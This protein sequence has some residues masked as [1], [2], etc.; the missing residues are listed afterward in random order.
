MLLILL[1]TGCSS[2]SQVQKANLNDTSVPT[3]TPD[4]SITETPAA[5]PT[6]T[7]YYTYPN[8]YYDENAWENLT[9]YKFNSVS[10]VDEKKREDFSTIEEYENHIKQE[11]FNKYTKLKN[12]VQ[13]NSIDALYI[14]CKIEQQTDGY[15]LYGNMDVVVIDTVLIRDW[16]N[17]VISMPME[18]NKSFTSTE[19]LKG[20][21]IKLTYCIY[22]NGQIVEFFEGTNMGIT[23]TRD[24]CHGQYSYVGTQKKD[25]SMAYNQLDY[26]NRQITKAVEE[27]YIEIY[28]SPINYPYIL[29]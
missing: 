28:K 24:F 19:A 14:H 8:S 15:I 4:N 10:G 22:V 27:R 3:K 20:T 25:N 7:P 2:S 9:N 12:Y 13:T 26:V 29:D 21:G 6:A 17:A 23:Y 11:C 18:E 16:A 5:T 1:L